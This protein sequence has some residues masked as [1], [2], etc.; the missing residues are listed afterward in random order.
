MVAKVFCGR[1]VVEGLL[2][3]ARYGMLATSPPFTLVRRLR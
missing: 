3:N 1:L 2:W